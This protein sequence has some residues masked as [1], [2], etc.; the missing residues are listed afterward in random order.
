MYIVLTQVVKFHPNCNY[1]LTGSSD[2]TC[3]L[4]DVQ[5]GTCVRI[6]AKHNGPVTAAAISP[7]G[8]TMASAGT[9]N[10]IKL[11]DMGSG[12]PIKSMAV[13]STVF[14]LDFSRNGA[15]L[16]SG[17]ADD[18]VRLWDTKKSNDEFK[19]YVEVTIGRTS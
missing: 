19:S 1:V 18:C 17:G 4:W 3:R 12:K 10:V 5:K 7:D 15:I 13:L 6:F 16:A 8:R 11:W 9:D 14:S 2:Q